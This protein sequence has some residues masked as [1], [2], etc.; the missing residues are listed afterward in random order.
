MEVASSQVQ[1]RTSVLVD[2]NVG[3]FLEKQCYC[4]LVS[5]LDGK[6]E[7]RTSV[8]VPP[9]DSHPRGRQLEGGCCVF[10][11]HCTISSC[12]WQQGKLTHT[13]TAALLRLRLT[14]AAMAMFFTG[15][16][17]LEGASAAQ[18]GASALLCSAEDDTWSKESAN[19]RSLPKPWKQPSFQLWQVSAVW[20]FP[21]AFSLGIAF[22]KRRLLLAE[23][24]AVV[25]SRRMRI[26][27]WSGA[28]PNRRP[29][30]S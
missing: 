12:Y 10:S 1:R 3:A 8:F 14:A 13:T 5:L 23:V 16:A 21:A 26:M 27:L 9:H 18:I 20:G 15:A 28:S 25:R 7:R 6:M 2:V 30:I 4:I 11:Q 17:P 19:R 22:S 24:A 29:A